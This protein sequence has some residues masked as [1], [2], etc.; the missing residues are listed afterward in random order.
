MGV[1]LCGLKYLIHQ[2]SE[3]S[4]SEEVGMHAESCMDVQEQ[5]LTF[6]LARS[7]CFKI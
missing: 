2:Q 1:C 4:M 5:Q 6:E 7:L 3:P